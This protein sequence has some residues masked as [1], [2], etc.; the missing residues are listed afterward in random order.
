MD[1]SLEAEFWAPAFSEPWGPP[2]GLAVATL[3]ARTVRCLCITLA[4]P[5]YRFL[6]RYSGERY[7]YLNLRHAIRNGWFGLVWFGNLWR[8]LES[9]NSQFLFCCAVPCRPLHNIAQITSSL[10]DLTV[11]LNISV[12]LTKREF[13]YTR[14]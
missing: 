10:R 5:F 7:H 12:L 13:H 1:E 2:C 14:F 6:A 3:V 8:I 11:A 9:W 4:S